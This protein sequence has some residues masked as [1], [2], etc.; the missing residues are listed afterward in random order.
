MINWCDPQRR[1]DLIRAL[2][3]RKEGK[4]KIV[5]FVEFGAQAWTIYDED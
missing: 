1:Y 2:K 3:N 5:D 4:T